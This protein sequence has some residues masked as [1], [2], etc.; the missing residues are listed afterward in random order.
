[1]II[2]R[3]VIFYEDEPKNVVSLDLWS[4]DCDSDDSDGDADDAD[5]DDD[6]ENDDGDGA[7]ATQIRLGTEMMTLQPVRRVV[8]CLGS[9]GCCFL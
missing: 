8:F 5:D 7:N 1:M 3:D 4:G 2:S 6:D 9:T